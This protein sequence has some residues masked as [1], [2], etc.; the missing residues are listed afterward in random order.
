[1]SAAR[2][3]LQKLAQTL[4]KFHKPK[5]QVREAE[6]KQKW[7]ILRGDKVQVVGNHPERGKQGIVKVVIREKDRVIVEGVN[8]G[9]R[10]IKGDK[11][12]GIQGKIIQLERSMH[13]SN[14]NLVDPVTGKP[15]RIRKKILETGEKV[16]VAVK[17]GAI[18]HRPDILSMRK[19][20]INSTVTES[21]T[22]EDDAWE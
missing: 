12:R 6:K 13:S 16:R 19:R 2:A 20:P 14:V 8:L 7:N 1:M 22:S 21:C 3:R 15:T 10:Q 17:S 5:P 9:P 11:D 18:I 4:G